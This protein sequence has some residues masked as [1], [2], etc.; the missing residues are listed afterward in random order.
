M[1]TAVCEP[2]SP[3]CASRWR[4]V[5]QRRE[6]RET[7][8]VPKRLLRLEYRRR[9]GARMVYASQKVLSSASKCS[10]RVNS[11]PAM[12]WPQSLLP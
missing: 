9:P 12:N 2:E 7:V 11:C 3:V 4:A 10:S 8:F 6:C 1:T 5:C